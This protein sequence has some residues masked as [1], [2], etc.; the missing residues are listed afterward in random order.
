MRYHRLGWT[1]AG[2]DFIWPLDGHD[3]LK[4]WGFEI[5]ASIDAYSRM[6]TWF[7]VGISSGT[8]RS[9]LAQYLNVIESRG[10]MPNIV[11]SDRGRETL[12]ISA[13]HY[14]LSQSRFRVLNGIRQNVEFRDTWVYGKSTHNA[15]IESWW[16]RL[17]DGRGK[18]WM[19]CI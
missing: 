13:A 5:Y 6:I 3:K 2:P 16:S 4:A 12:L 19:L 15:K 10:T 17:Q 7:Y 1:T 14:Y 8:L 11:R 9:V 18:F